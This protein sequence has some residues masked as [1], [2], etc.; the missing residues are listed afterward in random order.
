MLFNRSCV[1][2]VSIIYLVLQ[3]LLNALGNLSLIL[4]MTIYPVLPS[5]SLD[6]KED[7]ETT[8]DQLTI[9]LDQ[10][11]KTAIDYLLG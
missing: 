7:V 2:L 1:S 9:K 3:L 4:I 5:Y 6:L 11:S 10:L 8:Q